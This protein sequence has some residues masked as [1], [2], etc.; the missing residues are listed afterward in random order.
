MSARPEEVLVFGTDGESARALTTALEREHLVVDL[1]TD[2]NELR[3]IFFAR[4]GHDLL[5]LL[6]DKSPNAQRSALSQLRAVDP[7]LAVVCFGDR[8]P[9][10]TRV[11]QLKH[12]HPGS[13][14]GAG[15]VLRVLRT[16]HSR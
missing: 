4:G 6:T 11:T 2:L 16:R 5:V 10:E 14:A 7:D 3:R 8:A 1:A 15:A 9:A 13:R 12:Y